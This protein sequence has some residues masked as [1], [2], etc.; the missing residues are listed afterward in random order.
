[1]PSGVY[2]RVKMRIRKK[3]YTYGHLHDLLRLN[4][5]KKGKCEFCNAVRT[6]QY[7]LKKGEEY[8]YDKNNFHE[9]CTPCHREYDGISSETRLKM[10]LA[11]TGKPGNNKGMHWK[12][13]DTSRMSHPPW[14]KGLTKKTFALT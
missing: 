6:T 2:E 13:E 14:N 12:V 1:M 5:P 9:L 7:A 8:L 10:S 3:Y 4:F 11:R